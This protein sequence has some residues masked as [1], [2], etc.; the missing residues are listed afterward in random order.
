MVLVMMMVV[1]MVMGCHSYC[2]GR[3]AL[4][5]IVVKDPGCSVPTTIGEHTGIPMYV[6]PLS[7]CIKLDGA[8]EM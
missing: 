7:T 1:V 5:F 2:H 4:S 6:G 3:L 8:K